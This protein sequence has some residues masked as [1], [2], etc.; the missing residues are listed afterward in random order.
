MVFFLSSVFSS[1]SVVI[2]S[3]FPLF[4]NFFPLGMVELMVAVNL[5]VF[6]GG[7]VFSRFEPGL[8]SNIF[9]FSFS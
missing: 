2:F 8:V 3:A 7:R 9:L 1:V 4:D 5:A 6:S